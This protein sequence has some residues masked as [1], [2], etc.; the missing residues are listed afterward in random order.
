[1]IELLHPTTDEAGEG[2]QLLVV[3]L[4][5][6]RPQEPRG[7]LPLAP[8]VDEPRLDEVE[9]VSAQRAGVAHRARAHLAEAE[10]RGAHEVV[11]FVA[12][13]R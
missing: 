6:Q 10:E 3:V 1:M 13:W 7:P 11:L 8:V 9:E 4:G 2:E 5:H 12:E